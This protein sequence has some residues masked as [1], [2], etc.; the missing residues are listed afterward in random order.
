[1]R[2]I[3]H[4]LGCDV[5]FTHAG[6][7]TSFS[8]RKPGEPF[9]GLS[10]DVLADKNIFMNRNP[11][12]TA[13]SMYFHIHKRDAPSFK[14]KTMFRYLEMIAR[15]RQPPKEINKFV[16]NPAWG[17]ENICRFNRAWLDFFAE[18][19]ANSLVINYE[20]AKSDPAALIQRLIEFTQCEP[21]DIDDVVRK[22]DFE[23]MKKLELGG[24]SKEL[25]LS[26]R[27]NG[28]DNS[29]K[30]RKGVVRGYTEY[31]SPETIKAAERIAGSFGFDI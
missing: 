25:R 10:V 2:Y 6:Q 21:V 23:S 3:F 31:L 14:L 16:L 28:D 24:R 9:S 30:V 7:G 1:M 15:G 8:K 27:R 29:M 4:L 19:P 26:G 5:K 20:D 13:V 12:D 22:S 11:L 17:V 18:N